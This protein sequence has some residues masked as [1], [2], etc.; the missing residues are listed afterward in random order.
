MVSEPVSL[1]PTE[2]VPG[3]PFTAVGL[4][5]RDV[6]ILHQMLADLR[7]I[8]REVDSGIRQFEPYDKLA[9]RVDGLTHRLLICDLSR[10]RDRQETCL[11]GFF[12]ER[13]TDLD[14]TP[15]EEANTA[16]VAEFT[17]YPGILSYSSIELPGGHWANLVLHD[18]P[19]DR[20]YW[21]R[22]EL[23]SQAV[24]LL[25]PVHYR[26]V[27]IHNGRMT[28]GL[29]ESPD[30]VIERTKYYDYEGDVEWRAQRELVGV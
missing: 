10:L 21:R 28:D 12:G 22:S 7:D 8:L 27:R 13:H 1:G 5:E 6:S 17:K 26:N 23:H 4:T 11:V 24:S 18:D 30:L 25:S 9:W 14:P 16:I 19:I 15:L 2:E 20:E 29:T 3:R